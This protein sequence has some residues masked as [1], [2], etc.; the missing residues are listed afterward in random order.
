MCTINADYYNKII[1]K[2]PLV[3]T[4]EINI[5]FWLDR[6]KVKF[7]TDSLNVLKYVSHQSALLGLVGAFL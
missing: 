3:N 1:H 4:F 6:L 5:R 7:A 2:N